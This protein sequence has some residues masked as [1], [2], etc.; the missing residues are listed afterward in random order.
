M[1]VVLLAG[2]DDCCA[3]VQVV[4]RVRRE[5]EVG[6]H[7]AIRLGLELN[8]GSGDEPA[9]STRESHSSTGREINFL[10]CIEIF[11]TGRASEDEAERAS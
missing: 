6:R 9:R 8:D 3:R 5:V 10:R 4:V 7:D 1:L 2:C 11:G